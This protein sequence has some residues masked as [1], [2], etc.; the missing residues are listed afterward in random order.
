MDRNDIYKYYKLQEELN[1]ICSKYLN[2]N[3]G[4]NNPTKGIELEKVNLLD[5]GRLCVSYSLFN[6]ED[7][8]TTS[9]ILNIKDLEDC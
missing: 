2:N 9:T 7:K 5:G 3:I 1:T 6:N 4:K 8:Y